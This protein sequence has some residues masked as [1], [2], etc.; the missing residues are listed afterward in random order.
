MASSL[1]PPDSLRNPRPTWERTSV[2]ARVNMGE[3]LITPI[4]MTGE[5]PSGVV[6]SPINVAEP[7]GSRGVSE[8]MTE[9]WCGMC[10][11]VPQSE[12]ETEHLWV[13]K[14]ETVCVTPDR[15]DAIKVPGIALVVNGR[16]VTGLID[17]GAGRTI[18]KSGVLSP[19]EA[20]TPMNARVTDF[21]GNPIPILGTKNVELMICTGFDSNDSTSCKI[22]HNVAVLE[23]NDHPAP[24]QILLGTDLLSKHKAKVDFSNKTITLEINKTKYHFP[25][26]ELANKP[27]HN[28][29]HNVNDAPLVTPHVS[30]QIKAHLPTIAND[31]EIAVHAADEIR[32]APLEQ[33]LIHVATPIPDGEYSVSRESF[34]FGILISEAFV[35]VK[36]GSVPLLL[37]NVSPTDQTIKKGTKLTSVTRLKEVSYILTGLTLESCLEKNNAVSQPEPVKKSVLP[38]I[39][40]QMGRVFHP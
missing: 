5:H 30:D 9:S 25:M 2:N 32:L 31:R 13:V 1:V 27:S 24:Y 12:K 3:E 28:Q 26:Q 34:D 18:V 10:R 22:T 38:R 36:E 7:N 37:L 39:T 33:R 4:P 6:L 21:N 11:V 14:G 15:D 23:S 20:V 35:T 17:T 19:V 16:K 40:Y 29:L 8:S